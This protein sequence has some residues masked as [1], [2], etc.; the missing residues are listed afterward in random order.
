MKLV[1]SRERRRERQEKKKKKE[2]ASSK[3]F[4]GTD[5]L[6]QQMMMMRPSQPNV[7]GDGKLPALSHL[8]RMNSESGNDGGGVQQNVQGEAPAAL[9]PA[10]ALGHDGNALLNMANQTAA[11]GISAAAVGLA[12]LIMN[13][14]AKAPPPVD[15]LQTAAA[16]PSVASQP[17][18]QTATASQVARE[19]TAPSGP[20]L[21]RINESDGNAKGN[22]TTAVAT[23][24]G[25]NTAAA[26]SDD[27]ARASSESD[28]NA[29]KSDRVL[30]VK[31]L[32]EDGVL[33]MYTYHRGRE[34]MEPRDD[35]TGQL[36]CDVEPTDTNHGWEPPN[37]KLSISISF[38]LT[39]S[40]DEVDTNDKSEA[41]ETSRRPQTRR[42]SL[43]Q[44]PSDPGVQ[45][46]E[47]IEWDLADPK[48]MT[49]MCFAMGISEEFGLDTDQT[50]ALAESIQKQ[51]NYFIQNKVSY[52]TPLTFLDANGNERAGASAHPPNLRGPPQLYGSAIGD[53][54]AGMPIPQNMLQT[55]KTV[56]RTPALLSREPSSLERAALP[57]DIEPEYRDEVL[58]RMRQVSRKEVAKK[59]P[60]GVE[61]V[62][63]AQ[64]YSVCHCCSKRKARVWTMP[65]KNPSH[66]LCSRHISVRFPFFLMHARF[67]S[68]QLMSHLVS[69]SRPLLESS[70]TK[71]T[72][73]VMLI[74]ARYVHSNV[75]AGNVQNGC[76]LFVSN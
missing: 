65:C 60:E 34:G 55:M 26:S 57:P 72:I 7:P 19:V 40:V 33:D 51:I 52:K 38:P 27:K 5:Q 71:V 73:L 54:K 3:I 9:Q 16:E 2:A 17:F 64:D 74:T 68:V 39:D 49:P 12:S 1:K 44:A 15:T 28:D 31:A 50:L 43:G 35:E 58:R 30:R 41:D 10:A 13:A 22:E 20:I 23:A 62:L 66:S 67:T 63:E 4:A 47:T 29:K 14:G 53:T 21:A 48:T 70:S 56:S 18:P 59:W 37:M 6:S 45:Y 61:R 8:V 76:R 42:Q 24:P 36:L 69:I 11:Q 32:D 25:D 46:N 75:T